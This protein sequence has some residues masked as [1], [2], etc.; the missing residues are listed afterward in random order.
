MAAHLITLWSVRNTICFVYSPRNADARRGITVPYWLLRSG[1][2]PEGHPQ[3]QLGASFI[4]FM[5]CGSGTSEYR[6]EV[7]HFLGTAGVRWVTGHK[8]CVS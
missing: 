7:I 2:E 4:R 5:I 8:R 1:W 3:G 6:D